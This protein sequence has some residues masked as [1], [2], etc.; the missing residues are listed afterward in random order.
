[1]QS[2]RPRRKVP[3]YLN[4]Y[5]LSPY[6]NSLHPFGFG[7]YHTGVEVYGREYSFGQTDSGG[8]GVFDIAPRSADGCI[9]REQLLLGEA[10]LSLSEVDGVVGK[11]RPKFPAREY[12]VLTRNCNTF[13]DEMSRAL[14]NNGIPSYISRLSR[15][16]QCCS[17]FLPPQYQKNATARG[18]TTNG[19]TKN[20]ATKDQ[21]HEKLLSGAS[22]PHN[23]QFVP[24]SGSGQS[25]TG[26]LEVK[27]AGTPSSANGN[28]NSIAT[29][30]H[31]QSTKSKGK[32]SKDKSSAVASENVDDK[33]EKM[34]RAAVARLS[35][36]KDKDTGT[37]T[38]TGDSVSST[39]DTSLYVSTKASNSVVQ[40]ESKSAHVIP[41][42]PAH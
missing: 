20:G 5:D 30:A 1:M 24:F 2:S 38:A 28:S 27:K 22:H 33:R 41:P 7:A 11:L 15:L 6:N 12:N 31:F 9:F 16:G 13:S 32:D 23:T 19:T 21:S 18:G 14:V 29:V 25:M 34:R 40:L 35:K 26:V 36:Q 37:T 10:M 39:A 17:C 42:P 8:S 3:V 4:V